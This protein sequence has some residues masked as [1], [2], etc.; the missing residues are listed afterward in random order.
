MAELGKLLA[1]V[2]R[3]EPDAIG[4]ELDRAGWAEIEALLNGLRSYGHPCSHVELERC[5]ATDS[6]AR[7]SIS[8]DGLRI[9]AAQGHSI[10]IDLGLAPTQPPDQLF[11]GTPTRFVASILEHGLD[12]GKRHDVHLST[13]PHTAVEVGRRRGAAVVLRVDAAR[14][15]RDG[16]EFRRSDNG[17]WL[18]QRV[19]P[20][21]LSGPALAT[22]VDSRNELR[23]PE[24]LTLDCRDGRVAA[25]AWGP[26]DG[27]PVL[28]MHGWLDNAASFVALAPRL[29]EAL[30][31]RI[32]S[33]DLPGH[34]L[35][36]HKHGPYHFIDWV[37]DV[38]HAANALG[39]Q[40]FSLLGHSMGAGIATL[41]AGTVPERIDRC[42]LIEGIGPMVEQPSEAARRLARALRA[43]QR[44]Q[45]ASK[46]LF[47]DLDSAVERLR[48][49]ATMQPESAR[50]LVERGLE[51]VDG[52]W[53]WRADPRL[54]IDSRVRLS[55]E[56]VHAFL[57]A[58][59]CPVLL[60]SASHGWPHD[61]EAMRRRVEAIASL[62]RVELPGN[63]HLHLDD[64][65]AV[66]AAIIPFLTEA[67]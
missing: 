43:E 17:V 45:D 5:V 58:I 2:L 64:A 14:M 49:A 26:A 37:A 13:D 60:I 34:G 29:C 20:E 57:R 55:E 38:V 53:T 1:W 16:F 28:C 21:Y 22:A 63:H 30:Q 39:W 9:R 52:G 25:L 42:V 12:R 44:K 8:A 23:V 10:P 50:I 18:T 54:R 61:V 46:R 66:A 59:Q 24:A 47:A 4:L 56:Q 19:P 6:K 48:E 27:R 65:E 67:T 36:E 32:V 41:V 62:T 15:H 51:R 7:F 11:H 31:L 3:H 33:L 40:R 35:S